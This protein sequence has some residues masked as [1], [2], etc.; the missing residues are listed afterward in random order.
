MLA[1]PVDR[2]SRT[3]TRVLVG[4]FVAALLAGC[5]DGSATPAPHDT[6]AATSAPTPAAS[7]STPVSTLP[8]PGPAVGGPAGQ[9]S[10]PADANTFAATRLAVVTGFDNYTLN[11]ITSA[12]LA[13]KL[14]AGQVYVPCDVAAG[15][16][17]NLRTT[18]AGWGPCVKAEAVTALLPR[19][20]KR[21]GLL[22]PDLVGP[23]VK[24]VPLDGADLFGEGP[25]RSKPY[26]LT[27]PVPVSAFIGQTSTA[28]DEADVRVVLST[29]VNCADRGVSRETNVL[30]KGWDWLLNAGTARY[31]GRHWD[32]GLR[33]VGRRRGSHRGTSAR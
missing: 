13:K 26:P 9:P 5:G 30:G 16:A 22:P 4:L 33:L 29:G 7:A 3:A 25:A 11:A 23:G 24:V 6:T 17:A 8:P 10:S 14:A 28:F 15:V 21:L 31:T 18:Q 19:T 1:L 27:V 2:V 20:S 32:P 12:A